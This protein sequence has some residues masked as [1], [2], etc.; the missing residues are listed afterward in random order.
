MALADDLAQDD[1]AGVQVLSALLAEA[2][3]RK[4]VSLSP[5]R[6]FTSGRR[7]DKSAR[8]ACKLKLFPAGANARRRCVSRGWVVLLCMVLVG[9]SG[10]AP[11]VREAPG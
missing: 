4:Q 3:Q 1:V 9:C 8:A 5:R 7:V 6:S 10:T 11:S 2:E